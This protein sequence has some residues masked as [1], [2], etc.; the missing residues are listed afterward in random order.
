MLC[1]VPRRTL[2]LDKLST[3]MSD[4]CNVYEEQWARGYTLSH[5][6]EKLCPPRAIGETYNLSRDQ[7]SFFR[8][9]ARTVY[10]MLRTVQVQ[11]RVGE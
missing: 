11:T 1:T 2:D 6:G 9:P 3:V 4:R 8:A 10:E 5:K 7:N